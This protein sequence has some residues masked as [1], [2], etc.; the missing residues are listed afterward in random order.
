MDV[1]VTISWFQD[2]YIFSFSSCSI[3]LFL[4]CFLSVEIILNKAW[5]GTIP[6]KCSAPNANGVPTR[7]AYES[8]ISSK[9]VQRE[10]VPVYVK[11][12]IS[13]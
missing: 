11:S 9:L 7:L 10:T 12:R 6:W 5:Y 4:V 3:T 8:G 2:I 1:V 13:L